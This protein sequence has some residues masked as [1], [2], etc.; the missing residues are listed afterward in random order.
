MI[1]QINMFSDIDPLDKILKT[2]ITYPGKLAN[3]IF[4]RGP[5]PPPLRPSCLI[6]QNKNG[7][8]EPKEWGRRETGPRSLSIVSITCIYIQD[9]P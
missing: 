1:C 2:P 6:D 4:S 9:V 8:L 7:V 5:P 3:Q